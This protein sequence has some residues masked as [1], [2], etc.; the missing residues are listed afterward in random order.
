MRGLVDALDMELIEVPGRLGSGDIHR[1]YPNA[2]GMWES[3]P[4]AAAALIL[5][6]LAAI[7]VIVLSGLLGR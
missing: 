6:G 4:I 1:R 7:S 3:H 2:L 5:V